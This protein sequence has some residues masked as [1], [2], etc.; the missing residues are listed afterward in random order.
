[1]EDEEL[2]NEWENITAPE[3]TSEEGHALRGVRT[4]VGFYML[5]HMVYLGG[6][7]L[8]LLW[9]IIAMFTSPSGRAMV[10]MAT[11]L[12]LLGIL[13]V[14]AGWVVAIVGSCYWL[15]APV[16]YGARGLGVACLVVGGMALL[17]MPN[18]V[19]ALPLGPR[20]GGGHEAVGAIGLLIIYA[21]EAARLI[22]FPFF[23]RAMANNMRTR[24]LAMQA[25][26]LGIG[27]GGTF[28]V[29]FLMFLLVTVIELSSTGPRSDTM[30]KITVLIFLLAVIGVIVWGMLI[31]MA[32]RQRMSRVR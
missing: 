4:G 2:G 17:Q 27:T 22:L 12:L 7:V 32:A 10:V 15:P 29:V 16:G 24:G 31:L 18:I 28:G 20:G 3:P 25:T 8:V 5:S 1:M 21:M 11:L 30:G 14:L 23:L 26:A 9:A 19:N 13:A 6:M